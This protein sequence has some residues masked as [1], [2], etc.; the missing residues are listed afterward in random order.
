[1][2]LIHP[3]I[4]DDVW[5]KQYHGTNQNIAVCVRS[6][7]KEDTWENASFF[8]NKMVISLLN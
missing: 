4:S 7:G 6:E 5:R 1:M 2:L 8:E 3:Q